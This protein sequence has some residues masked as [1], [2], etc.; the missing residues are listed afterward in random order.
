MKSR[1]QSTVM[2]FMALL[3]AG[4]ISCTDDALM[5]ASNKHVGKPFELTVTQANS[6]SRVELGSDGLTTQW[7]PGDK[8]VLIDKTRTLAPIF[9]NCTLE[10]PASTASFV[11]ETGVPAGDYYVIYNYSENLAYGHKGFQSVDEINTH[12]DLVFWNELNIQE[13]E[14]QATISLNHLYAKVKVVLKNAP[15]LNGAEMSFQIGMYSSKKGFPVFQQFTS[16]GLVDAEYGMNPNSINYNMNYTYFPSDRRFHNI[17]FG[18]YTATVSYV[19]PDVVGGEG[20]YSYDWSNAAELS[21]LILPAD[22]TGEDMFF[23]VLSGNTC[24]EFKKTGVNFK[25]GTSYKV[26]LDMSQATAES[27]LSSSYDNDTYQNVYQLT[28]AA[29]WRH[30]A[31][32]N[33]YDNYAYTNVAYKVTQDIDF[34]DE[35]FFPIATSRLIGGGNT[36]SNI[37]LDWSDEDNVGLIRYEWNSWNGNRELQN[38][39]IFDQTAQVSNLILEN[40]VFK[41][42]NYVGSLGGCNINASNCEVIGSSTIE[43]QG[44][45][46]GGLV[47]INA[48]TMFCLS[49][50]AEV[51]SLLKFTDVRIGQSCIVNGKNNVGGIVG[52]YVDVN[53]YSSGLYPNSSIMSIESAK[54]EASVS[55]TEDYVGGIFGKLGGNIY[56]N[57][58]STYVTFS[59]EDYIFSL[60]KCVNEGSV[61][62]RHYVGGIGGDFAISCNSNGSTL[63][64]VVL[65]QSCSTGNVIGET[66]VGGILG[67]SYAATNICYSIGDITAEN[68]IVGGIVGEIIGGT[69]SRVAN[70]YSLAKI[71]V[72]QNGYAG[73]I[74]GTSAMCT[75][76]NSYYAADPDTYS[77]GGIVGKSNHVTVISNCLT[78]LN[79]LGE[80]DLDRKEYVDW[81]VNGDGDPTND[82]NDYSDVVTNSFTAN[83]TLAVTSILA[84]KDIINGDN[85][86]SNNIWPIADY[87]WECVKFASFSADTNIPNFDEDTIK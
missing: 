41:G 52:A 75:I 45:Y 30:A 32:R 42:N 72:G 62:G 44:N 64:R 23:Y 2:A 35:Y 24:Y 22:L 39:Q 67:S 56:G 68:S 49:N 27:M 83:T 51:S 5:E 40:V 50:N 8:L 58:N 61:S 19:E 85:A 9:L 74:V 71:S 31:Y 70:C 69:Y 60:T 26:E 38:V 37:T 3:C 80:L 53:N 65:S 21:A 77:F 59:M 73:G 18:N 34:T 79:S 28:N 6:S 13:G 55:A 15:A 81:D 17:R 87:K 43:G 63:D 66:K 82:Y 11:A 1:I 48:L 10:E 46:V 36:L 57:S 4:L 54:S 84:N 16:N 78:T 76:T 86:Y 25:P 12:D 47:G 33:N 20:S 7:E 14:D 29:D